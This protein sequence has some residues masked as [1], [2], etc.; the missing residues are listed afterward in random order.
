MKAIVLGCGGSGG[1]PLIGNVWGSCNP[2]NKKNKRTRVSI[3]VKSKKTAILVDCSPDM[4]EQLLKAKVKRI[5][6][7]LITHAHAD[8]VHGI[9]DFRSLNR[10]MNQDIDL[11][12]DKNTLKILKRRFDYVF[13]PLVPQAK[14]FYYK[15]CL[16]AHRTKEKFKIGDVDVVSF[17]QKHGYSESLGY[18][19]GD[20]AYS[21]DVSDFSAQSLSKLRGIKVWIV[22]CLRLK[23]HP[24]HSHLKRTLSWIKKIKP[25]RAILTHLNHEVDYDEL[26]K[27]LPPGVEVGFDGMKITF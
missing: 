18:R 19:F 3:L 14:G 2:K 10:S 8:H 20:L 22:D 21:T 27:S 7:V 1:V 5:N 24:S 23:P 25:E 17:I 13:K 4:R 11:Y 9:D 12:A 15:P 16:L 26:S 6:A